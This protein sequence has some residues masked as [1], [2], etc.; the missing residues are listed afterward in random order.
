MAT[1]RV[2]V[3]LLLLSG[4][5]GGQSGGEAQ[6]A[7]RPAA[8][9]P[10][11][12]ASGTAAGAQ[13]SPEDARVVLMPAGGAPVTVKVEIARTEAERR[14]GLMF[15][16]HMDANAGMLFLFDEPSQLSFWMRNTYIPLDMI[17]IE[18]NLRVL[19]IVENAEPMTDSSRSV[20]G[21]SQYVLEVN[22]GFSRQHGLGP[23]MAVR[24][25]GEG[26]PQ[27]RGATR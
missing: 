10:S 11:S 20:P 13:A 4:C 9:A 14:R 1:L 16:Q 5:P 12:S 24:F 3:G 26:L 15:R 18:P 7:A 27:A 2:I 25:E 17:F 8:S 6:P 22:A 23:G 21:V 19:G